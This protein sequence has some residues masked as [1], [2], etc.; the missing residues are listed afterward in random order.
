[1]LVLFAW[2]APVTSCVAKIIG[3]GIKLRY[4]GNWTMTMYFPVVVS[5]TV[6]V[7]I[8]KYF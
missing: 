7:G 6:L 3:N 1:M 8:N 2:H 4:L 5:R